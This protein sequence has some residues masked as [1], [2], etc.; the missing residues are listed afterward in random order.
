[1]ENME[2]TQEEER[3]VLRSIYDGDENFK[4]I[5]PCCFQYKYGLEADNKAFI[6][7]IK[8]PK[9]YPT[10]LP[11]VNLDTFFNKHLPSSLKDEIKSKILE[12]AEELKDSPM[13]YSLFDWMNE[14]AHDFIDKIP[15]EILKVNFRLYECTCYMSE[16]YTKITFKR[17]IL[18]NNR[19]SVKCQST[20]LIEL[21]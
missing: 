11:T 10:E 8:W 5:D 17:H 20:Q 16:I 18:D 7:E 4:E 12:Q 15:D 6:L 19:D 2:D 3:D 21:K 9:E 14:N 1:M 13:T